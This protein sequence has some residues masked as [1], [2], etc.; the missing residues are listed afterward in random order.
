[1]FKSGYRKYR[2][3]PVQVRASFWYLI[4][5]FLQK[6]ISTL[7]TPIFTRLLTTSEYGQYSVFNSWLSILSTFITLSM[8]GGIYIQSMVKFRK[9]R[10]V[11]TSSLQ[12]L[13]FAL[14]AG[15]T[16]VYLC[17][18][19]FWNS[20]L[21]L[22]TVQM[23]AMLLMIWA[24]AV[25][26]VWAAEQRIECRYRALVGLTMIV[27][28]AKPVMGIIFVLHAEDRVTARILSLMLA[29]LVGYTGLFVYHMRR[30]KVFCSRRFWK[31]MLA[32]SIPLIPHYLSQT[33]LNGADR[34]MIKNMVG[35]SEAGIYSLAYSIS[36]VMT[37]FNSALSQTISPWV[38]QKIRDRRIGDISAVVCCALSIIVL[39]NL[40]LIVFAPEVVRLFAPEKYY[41]AI[42]VIP[43]IAMSTYF[44]FAYSMFASFEFYFEKTRWIAAATV[45]AAVFNIGSN[46]VF[47]KLFGYYA[48]GYTTL[49][50]YFFYTLF[51]YFGMKKIC[52]QF[53]D[54]AAVYKEKTL[55]MLTAGFL[56]TGFVFLFTY[57]RMW[58]RYGLFAVLA[59]VL[60]AK[61]RLIIEAVQRVLHVRKKPG[62]DTE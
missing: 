26:N 61:R 6:G 3:L 57:D 29:E 47:I 60:A 50:S 28:V 30:G 19:S 11:L 17:F 44:T 22:T 5:S 33:V 62:A 18:R 23:L 12:G 46:Y 32:L 14:V 24:S 31:Y 21:G 27:T 49:A 20:L 59:V 8:W 40:L 36:Q 25:Y 48:A 51:H 34:I 43:P 41:D 15:W 42:W 4:C 56:V 39:A 54:G 7:T 55:I 13:I 2:A 9:D 53:F 1:M 52:R 58:L 38:Y 37:L 16:V 10:A 45:L 35:Q